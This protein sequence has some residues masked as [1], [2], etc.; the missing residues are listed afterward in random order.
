MDNTGTDVWR[1]IHGP[2]HGPVGLA[3]YVFLPLHDYQSPILSP[4]ECLGYRLQIHLEMGTFL[5]Y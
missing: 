1:D 5:T 2:E 4:T 3:F